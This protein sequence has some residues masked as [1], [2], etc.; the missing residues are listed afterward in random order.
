MSTDVL[1]STRRVGQLTGTTDAGAE[2]PSWPLPV[3]A[4]QWPLLTDT[5][6]WG[7][8]GVDLGAN[9]EHGGRTY[10]FFGDVAQN[11]SSGLPDNADLVAWIDDPEVLEHGGHLALGWN[12]VL[13]TDAAPQRQPDWRFCW[14]CQSLFW[15][16]DAGFK[17]VCHRGNGQVHQAAGLQFFL[18]ARELGAQDGQADW[19]FCGKCAGLFWNGDPAFRGVC[20]SDGAAHLPLGW[21]FLLPSKPTGIAGQADWRYCGKCAGMHWDGSEHKGVCR[22]AP[23]GGV[24]LNAVL[25][26]PNGWF[27]PFTG[28]DPIGM[29]LSLETPNGAFSYAGRV[30]VF[31]GFSDPEFSHHP[32]PGDPQ[33]G[34]YLTSKPDPEN[35]GL[36]Q[37]EF[38]FSPR[39]GRCPRDAGRLSIESHEPLGWKFF[40]PHDIPAVGNQL[41]GYR[42]CRKCASLYGAAAAAATN[43]CHAGGSHEPGD[44]NYVLKHAVPEDEQSQGNWR[45]CARCATVYWNGADG[46]GLC[47]AGGGHQPTEP[48][49]LLTHPSLSEDANRQSRWRFC[50]KCAGL[51]WNG[52]PGFKGR[53]FV[54]GAHEPIGL[55]FVLPHDRADDAQHQALWRFCSKCA[56]L[57]WNGGVRQGC[58]PADGDGHVAAGYNFV[59]PHDIAGGVADQSQWR[60]CDKCFGLFFD[61]DP[62]FKGHCPSDGATHRA[63]GFVFVLAHNPAEDVFTEAGWRY[64]VKCHAAVWTN[65]PPLFAWVAPVVVQNARH[66]GLPFTSFENGLVMFG[67]FYAPDPG[68]RL[69]WMPLKTPQAPMLQDLQYYTG[70]PTASW[71]TDEQAARPLF[72]HANTY[73]HVSAA[74][75]DGPQRWIVLYS[76]ANDETGPEGYRRPVVAR[77]GRTLFDWSDEL[78][79]F[80]P[81]AQH[82]YGRY[83]HQVGS[84]HHINPDI[85]PAQDPS[86]PEHDGWAYGAFV[87]THYTQWD[88]VDRLLTLYYLLSLSSPYQVQLMCTQIR[89]AGDP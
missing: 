20:P 87:L 53:C 54:G 44:S 65:Q 18:P 26:Q 6:R 9:T 66:Q 68:I 47:P 19:R 8:I 67:F 75:L 37:K 83:M 25:Q 33:P 38:L 80:D 36:Y 21:T 3:D 51:F 86:K 16:G 49:L 1:V 5:G 85:P 31:A 89:L 82:A 27:A 23:G 15:D 63:A 55:E 78:V 11:R 35:A 88:A 61:G 4:E 74:W 12:F 28:S 58:C 39:I 24:R 41:S 56:G 13:P 64:C 77:I 76:H 57:F 62:N 60:F 79:I 7:V 50:R 81:V 72:P 30:W 71:S 43:H 70:D 84:P 29:T 45:Q 32:R 46:G 59:L 17:G 10:V 48:D 34:C 14:K 42:R 69:A 40:L 52:N 22:G 2:H 73:T